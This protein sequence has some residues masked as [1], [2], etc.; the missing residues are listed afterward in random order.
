MSIQQQARFL[1]SR[2]RLRSLHRQ[3][4]LLSR[5]SSELKSESVDTHEVK[6]SYTP[7]I[8]QVP[9]SLEVTEEEILD[10]F[11][12]SWYSKKYLEVGVRHIRGSQLRS[13][14]YKAVRFPG[15][16]KPMMTCTH[17]N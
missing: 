13:T 9:L 3:L 10:Q 14:Q 7:A 11:Q 16:H 17:F 5:L 12:P 8:E 15:H 6:S 4:S 2:Q 1:Q